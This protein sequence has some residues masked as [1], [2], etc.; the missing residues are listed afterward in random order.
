MI[1]NFVTV[2]GH[3]VTLSKLRL[4]TAQLGNYYGGTA[5]S[6]GTLSRGGVLTQEMLFRGISQF[7]YK[8]DKTD[9][10]IIMSR[11]TLGSFVSNLHESCGN[12][13]L[14][15]KK[16]SFV[17]IPLHIIQYPNLVGVTDN[18]AGIV[19]SYLI[20]ISR[21]FKKGYRYLNGDAIVKFTHTEE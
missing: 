16:L 11:R 1:K 13:N 20:D 8:Y 5:T 14:T 17:G 7:L 18:D 12:L 6:A 9:L 2:K 4:S 21:L 15:S 3:K 10:Q 19:D